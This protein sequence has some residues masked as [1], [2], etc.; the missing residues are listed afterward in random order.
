MN[1]IEKA[2]ETQECINN[3]AFSWF[4]KI[5]TE[6]QAQWS[7]EQQS[8]YWPNVVIEHERL[9]KVKRNEY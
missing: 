9:E 1:T 6:N 4:E 5:Y 2:T 3:L 7:A 8:I